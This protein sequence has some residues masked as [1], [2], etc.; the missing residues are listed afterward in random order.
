MRLHQL[1]NQL[2]PTLWTNSYSLKPTVKQTLNKCVDQ[3]FKG[4]SLPEAHI[5]DIILKGKC[6]S[7][8]PIGDY[9]VDLFIVYDSLQSARRYGSN[10]D[11]YIEAKCELWNEENSV[12]IGNHH[13]RL[14]CIAHDTP[15]IDMPTYS[16]KEQEWIVE[17]GTMRE[18][19]KEKSYV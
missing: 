9:T 16:I 12:S 8:N 19:N 18:T 14:D 10:V 5:T 6:A 7:L 2:D 17:P 4:L 11:K 1:N 15:Q 3:F 13:I